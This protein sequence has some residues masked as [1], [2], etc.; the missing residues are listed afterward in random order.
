M[1]EN[2]NTGSGQAATGSN[3]RTKVRIRRD[4]QSGTSGDNNVT[5]TS[6][7][8]VESATVEPTSYGE[9]IDPRT[10]YSIDPRSGKPF[11]LTDYER[12]R[13]RERA[14]QR[15]QRRG[16]SIPTDGGITAEVHHSV[17]VGRPRKNPV[18]EFLEEGP[19]AQLAEGYVATLNFAAGVLVGPDAVMNMMESAMVQT[20]L[21]NLIRRTPVGVLERSRGWLDPVTLIV[22]LLLWGR[23]IS[24]QVRQKPR[25]QAAA[26]VTDAAAPDTMAPPVTTVNNGQVQAEGTPVGATPIPDVIRQFHLGDQGAI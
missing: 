22:A 18:Q 12:E 8:A 4:Q 21:T 3:R 16:G 26:Q 10:H 5:T 2:G 7:A 14:K 13:E 19:A 11:R 25:V 15:H 9:S 20:P 17:R 24:N 6:G 1:A 23:R